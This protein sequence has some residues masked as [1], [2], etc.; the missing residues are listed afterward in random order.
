[1]NIGQRVKKVEGL[2]KVRERDEEPPAILVCGPGDDLERLEAEYLAKGGSPS[3][4]LI[5]I[6]R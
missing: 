3:A 6:D 4:T 5:I 2:V 1:M